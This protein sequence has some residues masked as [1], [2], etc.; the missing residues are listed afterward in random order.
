MPINIL[1]EIIFLSSLLLAGVFH[2]WLRTKSLISIL[3]FISVLPL[4]IHTLDQT[5]LEIGFDPIFC[6]VRSFENPIT[7]LLEKGFC[8]NLTLI[9][10]A[11]IGL[12]CF[13]ILFFC[14]S[15]LIGKKN[16]KET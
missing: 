14:H 8:S 6:D 1:F 9:G 10:V 15:F 2:M 4:F 12:S 11:R 13:C 3:M 5:I 7:G 16:E